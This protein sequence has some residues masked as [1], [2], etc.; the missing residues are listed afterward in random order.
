[1][2]DNRQTKDLPAEHVMS[3]RFGAPPDG[4]RHYT[5]RAGVYAVLLRGERVLLTHQAHPVPEYQLPGGGIDP[6]ETPLRALHREVLEETGWTLADARRRGV[7]HRFTYMPEYD[8]WARKTCM[9][10]VARP[11]LCRRGPSEA[12]H[13]AHWVPP[14]AAIQLV[15]NDGDRQFLKEVLGFQQRRSV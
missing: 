6:G 5:H 14:K 11:V 15:G 9:V 10:Y 2:H 12:N 3:R 7:F 13:T 1:M 4:N 8:I